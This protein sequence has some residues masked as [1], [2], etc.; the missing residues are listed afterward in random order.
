MI[1]RN[2][3]GEVGARGLF[4]GSV[5]RTRAAG[6]M[7]VFVVGLFLTLYGH[8]PG[9]LVSLAAGG[10]VV[11]LTARTHNGSVW[12]RFQRRLWWRERLRR[13]LL[14]FRPVA[15]R[16]DDMDPRLAR[17]GR[18]R[19]QTT[20]A[21]NSFRDFP[22]GA[23]MMYWLQTDPDRPGIAW[24]IPPGEPAHLSVAFQLTGAVRGIESDLFLDAC[25]QAFGNMLARLASPTTLPSTVQMLTRALPID[26]ARH[27]Q[28]VVAHSDPTAPDHLLASYEEVLKALGHGGLTQRHYA[29]VRWPLTAAFIETAKRLGPGHRG[30]LR[31]MDREVA[32]ATR[33]LSGARLGRVRALSATQTAAIIRHLQLPDWPIDQL[34]DHG[35]RPW[36]IH[37]P[38]F[39]SHDEWSFTSVTGQVPDRDAPP[40]DAGTPVTVT[41]HHRTAQVPIQNVETGP[42]TALWLAPLLSRMPE[43]VVRTLSVQIEGV[44]A[45]IAR[46]GARSD[47]AADIAEIESD[48]KKGRLT[49]E[50]AQVRLRTVRARLAD[51]DPGS[52]HQGAGWAMHLTISAR[53][54]QD[55]A[56]ASKRVEEA[57]DAAGITGLDWLDAHQSAAMGFTWPIARGMSPMATTMMRFIGDQLAGTGHKEALT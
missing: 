10:V 9:L 22:D 47:L 29:V 53:T 1:T 4:G 51:L 36:D 13:G 14:D 35:G 26:S 7:V 30:W 15:E 12:S 43:Q 39:A 25:S 28:W 27:E 19:A 55:L 34:T 8:L 45:G 3:G 21:W 46:S 40:C 32:A 33:L 17:R 37:V 44:P 16:R 48:R 23:P 20:V 50:D 52:G 38:W 5:N 18:D 42:R 49:D 11:L 54:R 57:A 31:L 24:H 56:D 6:L 2:L 41:W